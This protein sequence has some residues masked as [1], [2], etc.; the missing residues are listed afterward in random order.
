MALAILSSEVAP[1]DNFLCPIYGYHKKR[2]LSPWIL[3]A[4][5]T[6]IN[7][8]NGNAKIQCKN[9]FLLTVT[10]SVERRVTLCFDRLPQRRVVHC[11][12]YLERKQTN[13]GRKTLA[14][15]KP[16]GQTIQDPS[17]GSHAL[18]DAKLFTGQCSSQL[19]FSIIQC[20]AWRTQDTSLSQPGIFMLVMRIEQPMLSAQDNHRCPRRLA[21]RLVFQNHI[22]HRTSRNNVWTKISHSSRVD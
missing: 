5:G 16:S 18:Y 15:E 12:S 2:R 4:P 14:C 22:L 7:C 13:L 8:L 1:Q 21:A 20:V 19:R 10:L 9:K 11:G 6:A 17:F 3:S